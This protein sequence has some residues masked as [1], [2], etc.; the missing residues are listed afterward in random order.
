ME[1]PWPAHMSFQELVREAFDPLVRTHELAAGLIEGEIVQNVLR[2]KV[3][4]IGVEQDRNFWVVHARRR[5]GA[6][7]MGLAYLLKM[8]GLPHAALWADA[9][10]PEAIREAT[11]TL[12]GLE[13]FFQAHDDAWLEEH[14]D[15]L[16]KIESARAIEELKR[17]SREKR[18]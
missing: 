15:A 13:R 9:M 10:T 4:E 5:G 2:S 12:P 17:R 18:D 16:V 8:A 3:V 6:R 1:W 11:D 7:W 14:Y